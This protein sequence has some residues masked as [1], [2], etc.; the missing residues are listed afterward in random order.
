MTDTY[1]YNSYGEVVGYI[2][3]R[4]ATTLYEY[5]LDRDGVGRVVG[6]NQVMNSISEEFEYLYDD[7]G[8]LVETD[9]N[10]VLLSSYIYDFNSNRVGGN[11]GAQPTTGVYDDQ[12]RLITYNT[13]SFVYNANGDLLSKTNN[14]TSQTTTYAYDAFGNLRQ[15]TIPPST[16]IAYDIDGLNRRIAKRVN[17]VVQKRWIY[18]DQY[19]IAA[20]LNSAGTITKRFV[21][22]SKSNV[23][24]YM[25]ASGVKYRI[26]SDHLGSPRLVVKQSDGS[27][28]QRMNHDE[29]GRVTED[30]NPGYLPFGFAGGLYDPETGL[31]R[32]G[33][34]DYDPEVGRWTSKDPILFNGGQSNLY[35][36]TFNDPVNFIDPSGKFG[37]AGVASGFISGM[38][39]G[40]ISGGTIPA[41]LAGGAA[42]AVVGFLNPFASSAAGAFAGGVASSLVGQVF[43][44]VLTDQPY[45][46]LNLGAAVFSGFGSAVGVQAAGAMACGRTGAA[47]VEGG[48]SGFAEVFGGTLDQ[49][50]NYSPLFSPMIR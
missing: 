7:A 8:R 42:G 27:I 48:A 32:F 33:V 1:S 5:S 24:D 28:A 15:V 18:M 38:V 29:F 49:T 22:G 11:I 35:G 39:G 10:S 4:G 30:T 34:R 17:G 47:V 3:K 16:T 44:N 13:W 46:N 12:D 6:K 23:P 2:A 20:E 9:K 37:I 26:I 43:G 45:M 21:Y 50:R 36:Y 41:A 14:T 40:Y 19:R 25:I 31:V